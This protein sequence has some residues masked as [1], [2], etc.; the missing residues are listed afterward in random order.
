MKAGNTKIKQKA[1]KAYC[2]CCIFATL[3]VVCMTAVSHAQVPPI[4]S[5]G[6]NTQVSAPVDIGGG[7]TQHNITGGTRPGGGANLFHS[8]GEFGVPEN[9]IANFLN[10]SAQPTSNIL[11]RVTGG[12]PSNILG[13]IQTEGFGKA[14]LF[15]MNPAGIV[16]GPNASLNVGGATHFTTADYLKLGDG[17][18]FTALT[19]AQDALLSVAPVAAFGFLN[20]APNPITVEGSTLSVNEGQTISLVSGDIT[21]GSGLNAPGG[22]VALASV[23]S[24]GEVLADSYENGPNING[25]SFNAMANISLSPG[26]TL[27]VSGDKVGTVIIR[28][29]GLQLVEATISADTINGNAETTVIDINISGDLSIA[30]AFVPALTART[31][32]DGNAGKVQISSAN[33]S[34]DGSQIEFLSLVDTSTLGFGRAGH[35]DISTGDLQVMGNPFAFFNFIDSGTVGPGNGGDVSI[36]AKNVQMD[37]TNLITGNVMASFFGVDSTGSSGDV[38]IL[39]ENMRFSFFLP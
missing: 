14:N 3:L 18:Q 15:L 24:S 7:V 25:Q 32:G 29:G 8:F 35:V 23:A 21:I 27:D 1:V 26:T 11:S 28:G 34:V 12:N 30:N 4:T 9:Q 19:S 16:F 10:D 37:F 6:L 39:S 20:S 22:K 33:M 13:T 36:T 38:T 5:S 2:H 17:M 31:F